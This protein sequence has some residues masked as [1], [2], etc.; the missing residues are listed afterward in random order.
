MQ[1]SSQITYL[2]RQLSVC[3]VRAVADCL[4]TRLLQVGQAG[5]GAAAA[6]RRRSIALGLEERG[7]KERAAH[8]LLHPRG[9]RVLRRGQFLEE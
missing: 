3:C 9:H 7:R 2:R 4:L 1:F 5:P 6:A 8:W